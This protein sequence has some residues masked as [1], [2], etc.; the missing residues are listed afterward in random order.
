MTDLFI[1]KGGEEGLEQIPSVIKLLPLGCVESQ[2][3]QFKVD[4]ESFQEMKQQ[5]LSRGIDIVIDYEHQTLKDVQAPAAG[6]IKELLLVDGAIAAKVDWTEKA[7]EYLKNK[8][9]RYISPVIRT[10]KSDGKA[11]GL[12]SA[13][14]TNTP[15]INNM[16]SIVNKDYEG[17]NEM[18][19]FK[20]LVELMGLEEGVTE[21]E[22]LKA[23]EEKLDTAKEE[24]EEEPDEDKVVANKTICG[25]L[26]LKA[27]ATTE[28]AAAAIMALKTKGDLEIKVLK[29]EE[30]LAK[31]DADDLVLQAM[32]DGKISPAQKEWALEYALKDSK[33]FAA[34]VDKAPQVV[35][36]G[37][38][39]YSDKALK[40]K[41]PDEATMK[42][43]KALGL[44]EEDIK[45]YGEV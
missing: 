8:E 30:Q 1:C 40:D 29:L 18:D 28:D 45:K 38:I 3:G 5:F 15:A 39:Q 43:C 11:V 26:G 34:F 10:R 24:P 7:K 25:L 37:E 17:G 32:K 41:S 16:Y 20:K 27:K 9:Y 33:G 42:I 22:L 6:W 13:G 36:V 2:K 21:E 44:T 19:L 12:H 4:E 35:P 14:L 23:L 31:R